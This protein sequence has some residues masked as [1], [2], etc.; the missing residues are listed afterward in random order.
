MA[1]QR[2]AEGTL[3]ERPSPAVE[4]VLA[5]VIERPSYSYEIWKRFEQRFAGLYPLSKARIYQVIDH[6][7]ENGLIEELAAESSTS[8]QPRVAYRATAEGARAHREWLARSIQEDPRRE[9]L[10][11]RLLAT[12][13]RDARAM[14]QVIEVYERAYLDE[15]SD[16]YSA[17]P[18]PAIPPSEEGVAELRDRLIAE[19]RRLAREAQFKFIS[20][21][22]SHIR[23]AREDGGDRS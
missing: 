3:R 15:V 12:G 23:A 19:E 8:R 4:A 13:A 11:R 6:L 22:R 14:L 17:S 16:G 5:L 2:P 7:L 1:G 10:L 21:A 18:P 9:E 20:F